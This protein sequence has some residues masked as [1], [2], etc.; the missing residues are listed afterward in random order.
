MR[1]ALLLLEKLLEPI[2]DLE[3]HWTPVV[4]LVVA[5]GADDVV[6]LAQSHIKLE[7]IDVAL[8][9][10]DRMKE[11]ESVLHPSLVA[12]RRFAVKLHVFNELLEAI[13]DQALFDQI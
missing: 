5:A 10:F 7:L 2:A 9:L 6:K 12:L 3:Q 11:L 13:S 8:R 4:F 1:L